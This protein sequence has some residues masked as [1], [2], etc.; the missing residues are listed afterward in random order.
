MNSSLALGLEGLPGDQGSGARR[1]GGRGCYRREHVFVAAPF[2]GTWRSATAVA[3]LAGRQAGQGAELAA[4]GAVVGVTAAQGDLGDRQV[5]VQQQP[6][7]L[8]Q[9]RLVNHLP[10]SELEHPL[11]VALQ[12][13]H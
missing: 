4:E 1:Q 6:R 10:W 11:A 2:K 9:A 5:S 3:V 13:R 8:F 7:G 12:L